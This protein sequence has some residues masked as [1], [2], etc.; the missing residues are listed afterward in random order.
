MTGHRVLLRHRNLN[1]HWASP[2]GWFASRG[3]EIWYSADEG[4]SWTKRN[5]LRTDW[6]SSCSRYPFLAQAGR[7]G[8]SNLICLVS[9][10]LICIA[11]GVIF[12]SANQ[13]ATFS[14]VFA[15]FQGRRPLRMGICQDQFCR[16]YLGEYWLN[17]RRDAVQLWRSEDDGITWRPVHTW[18]SGTVRHI[19]FVQFDPHT[20]LIWVGTGDDDAECQIGYSRDGGASFEPIGGGSQIWRAVSVLF[21]PEAIFW[22]TDIGIDHPDQPNYLVRWERSTQVLHRLMQIVG[23]AYYSAQTAEGIL[24]IGT[25]VEGGKNQ[26]D[27]CVHL[28]LAE[29]DHTWNNI[30]LWRKW[31]A[32]GLLGPS[33]ITFPLSEGPLSRLLFNANFVRSRCDGGLFEMAP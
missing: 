15:E 10:T 21:T 2:R 19:H 26:K 16:I 18:P 27:K 1:L 4:V 9:G 14:P 30:R 31:P 7:L 6:V 20:Q 3:Y 5:T 24:A 25:A 29:N 23:P 32:P 33:T 17:S 22:G 28:Y 11:D 8:I 12:R 13:G